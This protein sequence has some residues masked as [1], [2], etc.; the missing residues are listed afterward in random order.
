MRNKTEI[1]SIILTALIVC[2]GVAAC[3]SSDEQWLTEEFLVDNVPDYTGINPLSHYMVVLGDIQE[4]TRQPE[5]MNNFKAS[6]DWLRIQNS[7]FGNIDVMLQVG[8]IT[9]ENAEWQWDNALIA[10]RPVAE[11]IPVI[12]VPGNH[13]YT[14]LRK[15][16]DMFAYISDRESSLFNRYQLPVHRLLTI[17]S[18]YETGHRENVIYSLRLGGRI[19]YIIALEFGP[20]PEVV[21]WARE[22]IS[23]NPDADCYI[24]THEWLT[25]GSKLVS[26]KESYSLMQFGNTGRTTTPSGI[27]NR[28]V[29]PYDNVIAVICGHNGFVAS[30]FTPNDVGREVPQILFNLQYQENGGDSMLQLWE[31]PADSDT[32]RTSVYNIL[33]KTFCD[34]PATKISFSRSRVGKLQ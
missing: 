25:R 9:D 6:M 13:D 28:I 18:V 32:I 3:S 20:R 22:F 11:N 23:A 29:S 33:K 31:M 34:D 2:Q 8:D 12:A 14:W 30:R 24:L 15:E 10:L 21:E 16:G 27:W 5:Y 17:V 4:Y 7:F 19:S 26:D 1:L